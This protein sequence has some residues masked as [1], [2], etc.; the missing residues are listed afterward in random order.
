MAR[1][2]SRAAS[3]FNPVPM[4][5]SDFAAKAWMACSRVPPCAGPDAPVTSNR[6]ASAAADA[7]VLALPGL[8]PSLPPGLALWRDDDRRIYLNFGSVQ[9][10]QTQE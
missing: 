7:P 1:G 5:S 2:S 6:P 8:T 4:A 3:C 9:L 10:P